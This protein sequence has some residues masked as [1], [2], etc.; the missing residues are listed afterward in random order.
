MLNENDIDR[1]VTTTET[2]F[3]I[4]EE[5]KELGEATPTELAKKLDY[6]KSTIHRYLVTLEKGNYLLR[7]G[8]KF[9]ISMCFLDFG[10][11]AKQRL[12]LEYVCPRVD[13]LAEKTGEAVWFYTEENGLCFHIYRAQ[14]DNAIVT[15]TREGK[16]SKIHYLASGKAILSQY[17]ESRIAK[18]LDKHGLPKRTE[19][20]ITDRDELMGQIEQIRDEGVAYNLEESVTGIHCIAAPIATESRVIGSIGVVGPSTRL[21]KSYMDTEIKKHLMDAT[22]TI[23]VD[24][25]MSSNQ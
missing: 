14:G 24:L 4:L 9:K 17:S 12:P 18:I 20:T 23:Q 5:I 11:E 13:D 21:E 15:G 7:E 1:P 2:T 8:G 22:N 16:V 25:E 19:N 10:M 3:E 6:S